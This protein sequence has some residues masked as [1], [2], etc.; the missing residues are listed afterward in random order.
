ME[1]RQKRLEE[2]HA[3]IKDSKAR[4]ESLLRETKEIQETI[5]HEERI[6]KRSCVGDDID[7]DERSKGK[8]QQSVIGR[9]DLEITALSNKVREAIATVSVISNSVL[10]CVNSKHCEALN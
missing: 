6:G 9:E 7:A 5:D 10:S 4:E 3:Q 2:L 1:A 8:K